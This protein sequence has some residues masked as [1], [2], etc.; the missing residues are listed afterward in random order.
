MPSPCHAPAMLCHGL[1]KSLAVQ[2]G[3]SMAGAQH[4]H[5]MACVNQTQPHCVNEIGKTQTKPLA[6]QHGQVVAWAQ[7]GICQLAFKLQ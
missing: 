6:T 1:E 2:Y 4:G 7:H 5:V 3:Q